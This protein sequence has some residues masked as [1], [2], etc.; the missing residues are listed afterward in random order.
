M[1]MLR[2][3]A[4]AAAGSLAVGCGAAL[5]LPSPAT[6]SR[7][8]TTSDL[9]ALGDIGGDI[10]ETPPFALSPDGR[11]L[12][13]T[14]RRPEVAANAYR[15]TIVVV[16]VGDGQILQ[17]MPLSGDMELQ[18]FDRGRLT[19][20]GGGSI[21]TPQLLW[22]S[23]GRDIYYVEHA[24]NRSTV[25]AA[26]VSSA[27]ERTVFRTEGD[28]RT[29]RWSG[30]GRT[31]L[32]ETRSPDVA[33]GK[34]L[35]EEGRRG[36]RYDTRW[37]PLWRSKPF[38]PAQLSRWISV[39][40]ATGASAPVP[41]PPQGGDDGAVRSPYG[42]ASLT[43]STPTA[44]LGASKITIH[45]P[46][47][48]TLSCG[49]SLCASAR[50]LWWSRDG[51]ALLFRRK[52]GWGGELTEIVRWDFAS[53]SFRTLVSGTEYLENCGSSPS[54]LICPIEGSD[55]PRRLVLLNEGSGKERTLIDPN[56]QWGELERGKVTRLHWRNNLGLECFGDLVL[57]PERT[58]PRN[59]PLVVVGYESRGFL[60]GGTGNA[61]PI[62]PLAARGYAV[63]V[64]NLAKNYGDLAPVKDYDEMNRRAYKDWADDRSQAS[65]IVTAIGMLV[66]SHLADPGRIGLTGFSAGN[67]RGI[68]TMLHY[69][70]FHAVSLMTCCDDPVAVRTLI[71]PT[72]SDYAISIGFPPF[73]YENG[74][75][76]REYSLAANA[77]TISA[78][79]LIQNSDREF[80]M[81]LETEAMLRED[82]KP[83]AAYVYPDEYHNFWQPAHI[84]AS[85]NRTVA[86]FDY[87]MLGKRDDD[88]VEPDD[89]AS[90]GKLPS[91]TP[92]TA[93]EVET[94]LAQA[95]QDRAQVS[96]SASS[97]SRK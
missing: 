27:S 65:S 37:D 26:T 74:A 22:S 70:I 9:M 60:R 89:I 35:E 38:P 55:T 62:F 95:V 79:I 84:L 16:R 21:V 23:D 19:D 40:P 58:D 73:D 86:W 90:W 66:H 53:N 57:P 94:V 88:L 47:G 44:A 50:E 64:Y 10:D 91:V 30:D 28:I 82:G 33:A 81:M 97:S 31:L 34:A 32:A 13:T 71:G 41:A 3:A 15:Q 69:D 68:W 75:A 87:F 63:L 36:Y 25:R 78:P 12:A 92:P 46:D 7:P 72:L 17:Q 45:R 4:I 29:V 59:L 24:S 77:K 18:R 20:I 5:A 49:N 14:I 43:Y 1:L 96:A 39:D 56:P 93:S 83:V 85:Y 2:A 52:G 42:S 76:S 61:V 11:L 8:V 48:R 6:P 54:G 67:E 80:P 51:H